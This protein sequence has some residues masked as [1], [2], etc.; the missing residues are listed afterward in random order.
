MRGWQPGDPVHPRPG[1]VELI[2]TP[3]IRHGGGRPMK[4]QGRTAT[5]GPWAWLQAGPLLV[6][7]DRLDR[8]V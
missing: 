6:D 8:A 3:G 5:P 4:W 2:P 7:L 1:G